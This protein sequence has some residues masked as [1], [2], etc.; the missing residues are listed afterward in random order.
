MA[1]TATMRCT[2]IT[3][4]LC[5]HAAIAAARVG[6]RWALRRGEGVRMSDLWA[7]SCGTLRSALWIITLR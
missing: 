7:G 2:A 6:A 4:D 1:M 3:E 5:V